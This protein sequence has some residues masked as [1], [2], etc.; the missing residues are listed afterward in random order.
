MVVLFAGAQLIQPERT[1]P[2]SDPAAAFAVLAKPSPEMAGLVKRACGNCHSNETTW[3]WYSRVAPVSWL[4]ASDVNEGRA[5]LNFSEW[6]RYGPEAS[7]IKLK[8]I[9]KEV[10]EGDM[11]PWYYRPAHPEARLT[12]EEAAVFCAPKP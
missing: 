4:V 7:E 9:C 3:P 2:P 10:R 5:K 6:N 11:P 8:Q 1:N 12:A